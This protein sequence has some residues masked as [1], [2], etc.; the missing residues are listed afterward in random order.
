[1]GE[2]ILDFPTVQ[3]KLVIRGGHNFLEQACFRNHAVLNHWL[4]AAH[5]IHVQ[6]H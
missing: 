6:T 1:M 5:G 3:R 4:E 2:S